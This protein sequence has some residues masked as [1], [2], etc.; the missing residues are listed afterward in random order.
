MKASS[1]TQDLV[2]SLYIHVPFCARK[3][4]YCAFYSEPSS[5]DLMDRYVA[6][7]Q[8][9]SQQ[10]GERVKPATIF[11]GGGTPSLLN[12]R[13]W[14]AIFSAMEA[15]GWRGVGEW[16]VECNPATVSTDKA[17]L[18][19]DHGVNRISMGVQSLDERLLER[20]GRVHS[21]DMVF[22][23]YDILRK[24][25]FDNLNIDLMF[26]I[27][28]Q[29]MEVW[30][31]TLGEVSS[32]ESEHLSCYEVMYEE[33][34][35]LFHQLQAGKLD[36]NE[37]LACAMYEE[38]CEV[39]DHSGFT[40]Y[41]VANFAKGGLT[42]PHA[43]GNTSVPARACRH[44][45][46]Y[47]RGGSFIGLGPSATSYVDGV[48][49]KNCANTE[50]YCEA[51]ESGGSLTDF[52]E[53]L[54][55]SS[56]AGETAAFGLRMVEGWGFDEFKSITGADLRDQWADEMEALKERGWGERTDERFRLTRSGLRFADAAA[57]MFLR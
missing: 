57:E 17:R 12:L 43:S 53:Q 1:H 50:R 25:G 10:A 11:F 38:L 13:Q 19:R 33:D 22:R 45:V 30:R 5:G 6:A 36:V 41:E 39:A 29:T 40:Q 27:P 28:G 31:Q 21:R 55:A 47:W 7:L 14:S 51:L 24:A 54:P 34:T 18:F 32:M 8:Q 48:R 20:L 23:S 56:R 9:E 4:E 3:C 42:A 15:A 46:N 49:W 2:Q 35:P 16:T 44:N 37:E 26:A 52:R